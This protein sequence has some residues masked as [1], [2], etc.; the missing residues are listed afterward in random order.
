MHPDRTS[1]TLWL[2]EYNTPWDAICHGIVKVV[3]QAKTPFQD[4][5][6]V[7]TG[8][9]GKA[10]VLDGCWQS[11]TQDEF[12][13]HEPLVHP[14]CLIQGGP[15]QVLVLGGGEGASLREVLKWQTVKAAVLVDLDE[16]VVTA[17]KRYLPE[18]HQGSFDDPRSQVVIDDA[19]AFLQNSARQWDVIISD[20]TDPNESGPSQKLFTREFFSCC[21]KA[22]RPG[23]CFVLQAGLTGPAE[24]G[25]HVRLAAIVGDLFKNMYHFISPIPTWGSPM[26][27]IVGTDR[28]ASWNDPHP[29]A[30]DSLLASSVHGELNYVD[31]R[32]MRALLNPPKYLR[33]AIGSR[34]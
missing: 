30:I 4:M 12:M 18:M 14:A 2:T 3:Y 9:Y 34:F 23:G 20:L 22:L 13:Y 7:E 26:G 28:D 17:C 31:G 10:L 1:S 11:S 32:T 29:D 5:M 24:M 16:Q 25:P 15:E 33:D 6:I 8:A 21:R 27:F 19:F